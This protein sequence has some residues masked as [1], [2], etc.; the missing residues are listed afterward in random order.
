MNAPHKLSLLTEALAHAKLSA[1]GSKKWLTCTP[2]ARLEAT[3]PD[4]KTEY[5][6][7]GSFGHAVFEHRLLGYLG[8]KQ[9]VE[10]ENQLP[11]SDKYY[12]QE[13]CDAVG[14]A[15]ARAIER[16]EYAHSVCNDPVILL[17]QRLDFSPWVP[18]GFG[19]GDLVIV[20]HNYV[21]VLDLK[22]GSGVAVSA[23]ENSQFRLYA[24]GAYNQFIH[25]YDIETVR[26]TVLQPRLNNYSSEEL[27]VDDLLEWAETFVVP[28]AKLAFAGEGEFH[29]GEHCSSGF[30]RARATCAARANAN[31]VIAQQDFALTAPELLTDDQIAL[32]LTKADSAIKWLTD[33]QA[34]ALTQA[35]AGHAYPGF[36]LVEGRANR[37]YKDQDA[38][39]ATLQANGVPE[40]IIY[41]R[42][43][44]GIT[45]MEKALGKKK[46]AELLADL[47]DKPSGKPV[48]V[49]A[50]DRRE[51]LPHSAIADFS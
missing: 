22:M 43:L 3:C 23:Y 32:V 41:E 14:E 7:E 48:L 50:T 6:A 17:E 2:S 10:C 8:R 9:S 51:E 44:L 49:A 29:P 42:S 1:S 11:G 4:Q 26:G 39:A 24:L 46:F 16:I 18:E 36:K 12:S 35:A 21:E 45:A 19:T 40:E 15:V 47:I 20:G 5:A 37:K 27:P 38:V 33:V 13:L 25:L 28:R 34:H 30:C 31:L